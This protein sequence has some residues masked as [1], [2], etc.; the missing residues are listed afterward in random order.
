VVAQIALS[1]A[2]LVTSALFLRTLRNI[3]TADPGFEQD[4][5]LTA[6]VG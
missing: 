1:L 5:I 3:A 4:R 6:S 2:L